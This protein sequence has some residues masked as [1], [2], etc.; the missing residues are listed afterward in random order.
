MQAVDDYLYALR[1]ERP[2]PP[3]YTKFIGRHLLRAVTTPLP[4]PNGNGAAR[5]GT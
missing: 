3:T 5:N 4:Q 1:A 2:F